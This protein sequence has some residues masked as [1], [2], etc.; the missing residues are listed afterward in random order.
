MDGSPEYERAL[1]SGAKRLRFHFRLGIGGKDCRERGRADF[2]LG[3]VRSR[4][5]RV[6][7]LPVVR[8]ARHRHG[9]VR[10]DLWRR[11]FQLLSCDRPF[12][13]GS[14]IFLAAQGTSP[15]GPSC[16]ACSAD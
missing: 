12:L 10:L 7:A 5:C 3:R 8:F 14:R 15:A 1:R 13:L 2:F 11:L 16:P 6:A 4:V 9:D